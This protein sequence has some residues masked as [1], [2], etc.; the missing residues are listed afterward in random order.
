MNARESTFRIHVSPMGSNHLRP[1]DRRQRY[2]RDYA[3]IDGQAF[4]P[5]P[6]RVCARC[7]TRGYQCIWPR[8]PRVNATACYACK[9]S[10]G[11]CDVPGEPK[12]SRRNRRGSEAGGS[13]EE[14]TGEEEGE[15]EQIEDQARYPRVEALE[16]AFL[17][18]VRSLEAAVMDLIALSTSVEATNNE[19]VCLA[20]L[21]ASE[22]GDGGFRI[23]VPRPPTSSADSSSRSSQS[24]NGGEQSVDEDIEMMSQDGPSAGA[25][26][27]SRGSRSPSSGGQPV[28]YDVEMMSEDELSVATPSIPFSSESEP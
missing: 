16:A 24:P 2:N 5:E 15:V 9:S 11:S 21:A 6:G 13:L 18:I 10:H 19:L 12:Q 28:D 4:V 23:H 25:P 22:M 3:E 26:S 7:A 1:L 27:W 8:D 17:G 14:E 20:D